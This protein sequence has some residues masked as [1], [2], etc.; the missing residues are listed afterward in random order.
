MAKELKTTAV[1]VGGGP[2]GYVCAIRLGQL[3]VQTILV[4]KGILGG[5]CLNVGCIP[6]KA[7][8]HAAKTAQ[9]LQH[10]D[11]IGIT[12]D[13]VTIDMK[14]VQ[15]WKSGIIK[16]LTGGV[17]QLCKG[18]GVDVMKGFG[19]LAD[20]NTLSVLDRNGKETHRISFEHAVLAT[21]TEAIEIPAF[22]FDGK[23]IISS[24]EALD[25]TAVP[26]SMIVIGGGYIGLE[27]GGAY[28]KLGSDVTVV[29]MMDQVLPGF[30]KDIVA[31]VAKKLRKD[32]VTLR[33]GTK[34]VEVKK[35][36]DSVSLTVEKDGKQEAIT[37]EKMLVS[38]GR[39]P[40]LDGMGFDEVGLERDG[41]F[42][43]VD[44]QRRTTVPHIFAIGD[45]AGQPMLAH[46]ASHEGEV[47]A[48]VIAGKNVA[49]DAA[50]IPAV[51]FTDPEI[52][53]TGL[54]ESEAKDQGIDVMTG[55]FPFAALGRA[56][57]T[58]D[59]TGFVK[60]VAEKSSHIIV[61]VQIV[62]NGASDMISEG[63]AAIELGATLEDVSLSVHPHPTLSEAVMEAAKAA[64]GEAIHTM[65]R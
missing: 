9:K 27:M 65:N 58:N 59:T 39:R 11:D 15:Q 26:E 20:K 14:K 43:K 12:A 16:K 37:A 41:Q 53:T 4:D 6:S 32:G 51:V 38:V 61:G 46:K 54:S 23:Q 3:G 49:Y 19:K 50:A 52:A 18:N 10:S 36:K 57:T 64:L 33:T 22:K 29:E 17:G 30:D 60:V 62:G 21:G 31:L 24:A 47:V 40:I 44:E 25:L 48:E 42:L 5:V 35:D 7:L 2:G 28:A 56:M 13:N 55:K 63:T 1:I 34:A 8:I 45:I